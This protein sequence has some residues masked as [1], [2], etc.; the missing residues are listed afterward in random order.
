MNQEFKQCLE[1]K[2]EVSQPGAKAVLLRQRFIQKAVTSLDIG[3]GSV[4]RADDTL[5]VAGLIGMV[6]LKSSIFVNGCAVSV[7]RSRKR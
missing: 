3:E 7:M 1:R 2:T 5:F 6:S 4:S